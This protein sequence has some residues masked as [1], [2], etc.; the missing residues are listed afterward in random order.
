MSLNNETNIEFDQVEFEDLESSDAIEAITAENNGNTTSETNDIL[1]EMC[2]LEAED[3]L[4]RGE[5]TNALSSYQQAY[6]YSPTKTNYCIKLIDLLL[7]DNNS[8]KEAEQILNKALLLSPSNLEL[9]IR[10]NKL[11]NKTS[12]INNSLKKDLGSFL[13]QSEISTQKVFRDD[14]KSIATA[15]G[16]DLDKEAKKAGITEDAA[17][18]L[19]EIDELESK[20]NIA[21][22]GSFKAIKLENIATN[23]GNTANLKNIKPEETTKIT[24]D[25]PDNPTDIL[26]EIDELETKAITPNLKTNNTRKLDAIENAKTPSLEKTKIPDKNKPLKTKQLVSSE[27]IKRPKQV[28]RGKWLVLSL[29]FLIVISALAYDVFS[30]PTIRLLGPAQENI[31]EAKDIKFEW[32][33]D[34]KVAS[35]VLEV[36]E[37]EVFI[38]KQFTKETSYTPTAEQLERF[39]PEHTYKWR[40]ILPDG[41]AGNYSFATNVKTFSIAKGFEVTSPPNQVKQPVEN[42][43]NLQNPPA[44]EMEKPQPKIKKYNPVQKSNYGEDGEI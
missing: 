42:Q 30:K 1:A 14:I 19:K 32:S 7:E 29:I 39:S 16:V 40:V 2:F 4:S 11:K 43:Q 12:Q 24:K 13:E 23:T 3:L 35:F 8:I 31:S 22:T 26:K 17:A 25:L 18:I 33:C 21:N 38:I 6:K 9:N 15:M 27:E 41:F 10:L 28:S 36:Y 5:R 37:D 34:K 44:L 20:S